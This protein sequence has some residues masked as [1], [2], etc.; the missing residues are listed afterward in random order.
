MFTPESFVV[1]IDCATIEDRVAVPRGFTIAADPSCIVD[2][3][4]DI[5]FAKI[6]DV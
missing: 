3:S 5:L 4:P 6:E 1:C 2:T